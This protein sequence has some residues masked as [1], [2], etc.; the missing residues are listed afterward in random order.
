LKELTLRFSVA[1]RPEEF[2]EVIAAFAAG[3]IDP[4]PMLGPQLGLDR[5]G[6]AFDLV[7]EGSTTGRVLV[8]ASLRSDPG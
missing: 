3:T 2:R 6:E 5:L 7:R 1:Y 4:S 8:S